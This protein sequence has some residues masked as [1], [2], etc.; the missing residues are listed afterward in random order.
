MKYK[1]VIF[2]MDGTLVN[3]IHAIMYSMNNVLARHG[4]ERINMDQCKSFV[5]NGIKELVRKAARVE[6]PGDERLN[7]YYHEMVEDYSKNWDY[8]M[9][10]YDG[11]AGLLDSLVQKNIKLG[12]NTNKNEDIAKLIIDKYFPGY[13][14]YMAGGRDS[15]PKKPDPSGALL[16]AEKL[17]VSPSQ[18]IYLGDSDVDIK[19]AKNA[20]MYAVGALWGFRSRE[21]L[22]R[23]GADAVIAEPMELLKIIY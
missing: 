3:S 15:M 12:V 20:K 22:I 2:D 8:Q 11:I 17:G 9:Y 23:A 4:L 5:G 18:C 1:A 13:F 10:A 16:I 21:E 6:S 19:T 14:S 7:L